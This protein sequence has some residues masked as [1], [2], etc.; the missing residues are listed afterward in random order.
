MNEKSLEIERAGY[1]FGV[2]PLF[3]EWRRTFNFTPVSYANKSELKSQFK[4]R[5]RSELKTC[6]VYNHQVTLT[7]TLYLNHEKILETPE[8]GDLDN[9]AKTI[10]D[11]IKGKGGV[12]IDDCQ[13]QRIDI[14]WINVPMESYF[15]IEL[16]SSPDAFCSGNV[17]LYEMND[18]LFYPVSPLV[19]KEGK[20]IEASP[21]NMYFQLEYLAAITSIKR[22]LRHQLR[23]EG[24]PQ[25]QAFQHGQ[26]VSPIQWAFHQTRVADSGFALIKRA[27]W[28]IEYEQWANAESAKRVSELVANYKATLA[29]AVG[30]TNHLTG[31]A[32]NAAQAG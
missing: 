8:Y 32:R 7:I 18:G 23:L 21:E 30:I 27:D 3:G 31:A 1:D 19:W 13:I 25:F 16:R 11:A 5:L 17:A 20:F 22:T 15:E 26:R 2:N 24:M 10:C 6:F 12:L 9:Y 4:E 28:K 29:K 14:S